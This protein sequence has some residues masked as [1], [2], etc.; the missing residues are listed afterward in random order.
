MLIRKSADCPDVDVRALRGEAMAQNRVLRI[1]W[2]VSWLLLPSWTIVAAQCGQERWS[3]KT[4]TDANISQVD[5]S[6][7]PTATT[8]AVMVALPKPAPLPASGRIQPTETTVWVV[9]ATLS[10]FKKESDSD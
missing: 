2:L 4:G 3:V 9:T 1:I 8:V 5:L 7:P 6:V 10:D